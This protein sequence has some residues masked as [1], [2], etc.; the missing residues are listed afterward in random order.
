[1]FDPVGISQG[2]TVGRPFFSNGKISGR[3]QSVMRINRGAC[4]GGAPVSH[5][6]YH[7]KDCLNYVLLLHM[8]SFMCCLHTVGGLDWATRCSTDAGMCAVL[9]LRQGLGGA[10]RGGAWARLRL[11]WT[12]A[13]LGLDCAG[14]DWASNDVR[15]P[16]AALQLTY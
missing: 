8:C 1:M 2:G 6:V 3:L 4:P 10:G 16:A 9:E 13:G 11:D 15:P 7:T 14:R 5:S 12:G